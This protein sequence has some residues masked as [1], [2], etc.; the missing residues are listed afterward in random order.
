M[1]HDKT[2]WNSL[3]GPKN[4]LLMHPETGAEHFGYVPEMKS[5]GETIHAGPIILRIGRHT[6]PSRGFG[7]NHIWDEHYPDLMKQGYTTAIDSVKFVS[8]II[9]PGVPI[10]CEFNDIRGKHRPTVLRTSAGLVILEPVR[11]GNGELVYSVI[12]AYMKRNASGTK[13]GEIKKAP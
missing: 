13:I 3:E 7:V 9:Q 1:K 5:K 8:T 2:K 4:R 12:T 10:Y 6:G 11:L